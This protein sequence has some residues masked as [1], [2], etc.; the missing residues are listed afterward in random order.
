MTEDEF[1]RALI[2]RLRIARQLAGL[3]QAQ[4]ALRVGLART[5]IAMIETGRAAVSAWHLAQFARHYG[6]PVAYFYGETS[7]MDSP[8]PPS[9]LVEEAR[10]LAAQLRAWADRQPGPEGAA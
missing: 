7:A 5:S 1:R 4:I 3:T 8:Q 6:Q 2:R 9:A 10:A